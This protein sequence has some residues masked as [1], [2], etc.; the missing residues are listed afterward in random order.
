MSD[1]YYID[2]YDHVVARNKE[3]HLQRRYSAYALYLYLTGKSHINLED[4]LVEIEDSI[5]WYLRV[6]K[7]P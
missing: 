3:E 4:C 2:P 5:D 6:D 7:Q 1:E